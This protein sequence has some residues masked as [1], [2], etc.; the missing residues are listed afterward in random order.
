MERLSFWQLVDHPNAQQAAIDASKHNLEHFWWY[1]NTVFE[2]ALDASPLWIC[3]PEGDHELRMKYPDAPVFETTSDTEQ[4]KRHMDSL[5]VVIAPNEQAYA[6]RFYQPRYL[7]GW[8]Q[9][10][11][12]SRLSEFLGPISAIKWR[13][14]SEDYAVKN[15]TKVQKTE[16]RDVAW[17]HLTDIDWQQLKLAYIQ[18]N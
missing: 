2:R 7:H 17:F 5:L 8:L 16:G 9:H 6:L 12:L 1:I 4:F 3:L 13:L 15:P 14:D 11:E 10:I 18:S